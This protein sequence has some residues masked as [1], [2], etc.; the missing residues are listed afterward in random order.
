MKSK[1]GETLTS[2]NPTNEEEITA[3]YAAGEEDVDIAVKAARAAFEGEAW[4]D[5]AP[6]QRVALL[7]K[8]ADLCEKHEDTLATI[9][10]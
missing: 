9:G 3:V 5:I 4:S 10:L 7:N 6:T 1:S 8:L 2:I